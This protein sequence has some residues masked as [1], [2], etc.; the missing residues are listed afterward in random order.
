MEG[1]GKRAMKGSNNIG[2]RKRIGNMICNQALIYG[3]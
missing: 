2:E 1:K 3:R